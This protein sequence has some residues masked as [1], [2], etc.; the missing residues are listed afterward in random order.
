MYSTS[1]L[2]GHSHQR[3]PSLMSPKIFATTTTVKP[4]LR[5]HRH[6]RPPVLKDHIFLS[7]GHTFQNNLNLSL[8]RSPVLT[9]HTF[10]WL[11][12]WSFKTS[13]TVYVCIYFSHSQK[14]ISL[15][16]P[17]IRNANMHIS[18]TLLQTASKFRYFGP[19]KGEGGEG[20]GLNCTCIS[21]GGTPSEQP[22]PQHLC[23]QGIPGSWNFRGLVPRHAGQCPSDFQG[24]A[25][26]LT[27]T[28]TE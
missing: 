23:F 17:K 19:D 20:G 12:G 11:M 18:A 5:N 8:Y 16:W 2:S 22:R 27:N 26:A 25:L 9:D 10:L 28:G 7:S 15:M 13:S 3:P 6:E 4:V 1:S 21:C 14:A 24:L